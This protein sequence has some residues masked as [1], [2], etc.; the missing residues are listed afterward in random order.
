LGSGA[1]SRSGVGDEVCV[2]GSLEYCT[3]HSR[4]SSKKEVWENNLTLVSSS[5]SC[6]WSARL[7]VQIT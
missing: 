6:R 1:V 2:S 5:S 4:C 7:L 3:Y